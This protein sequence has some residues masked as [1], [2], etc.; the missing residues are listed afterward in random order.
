MKTVE[1]GARSAQGHALPPGDE[2]L[3]VNDMIETARKAA[4]EWSH[5]S[6]AQYL[7]D[8]IGER[9][10]TAA[11]GLTDAR[12]V[13]G[14]ARDGSIDDAQHEQRL[15]QLFEV[16]HVIADAYSPAVAITFLRGS[17][18]HLGDRSP[19]AVLARDD[20]ETAG[21]AVIAAA[22]ALVEG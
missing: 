21:P 18:P 10:T 13:R 7:I 14:W 22:H 1:S 19:L 17:N 12:T 20:I 15:A 16:V 8:A 5:Q 6:K 4:T 2:A 11:V 9:A 3:S